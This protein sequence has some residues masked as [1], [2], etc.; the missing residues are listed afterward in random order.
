MSSAAKK[1]KKESKRHGHWGAISLVAVVAVGILLPTDGDLHKEI[2]SRIDTTLGHKTIQAFITPLSNV[3]STE[4]TP[5][6][7]P[8]SH[9][10]QAKTASPKKSDEPVSMTRWK[11]RNSN[12]TILVSS[13]LKAKSRNAL[14]ENITYITT[15]YQNFYA[16]TDSIAPP[17]PTNL[18]HFQASSSNQRYES[19][20]D[21]LVDNSILDLALPEDTI[22]NNDETLRVSLKGDDVR[23]ID[24]DITLEKGLGALL[25]IES[26]F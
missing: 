16:P 14:R 12:R 6:P 3:F 23:N 19:W 26:E 4:A 1:A 13:R 24:K 11:M 20:Q 7:Q 21:N 17:D 10:S 2:H 9:E 22:Q 5:N 25:A 18:V 8:E 15:T